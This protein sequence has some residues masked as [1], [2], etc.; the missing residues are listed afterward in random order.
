MKLTFPHMGNTYMVIKVLLDELG[1]DYVIPP[2]NNKKALELGTKH[3][4]EMACLPLKLNLGNY[5]QAIEDGADTILIAGGCGPCRFGYYGEVER[6]ILKDLG[7]GAELI[8]LEVPDSDW[9]EFARRVRKLSGGLK[10]YRIV[11]AV[12]YATLI[13]KEVDELERLTFRLRPREMEKG[14]TDT[15]YKDFK[16]KVIDAKGFKAVK[17]LLE[18]TRSELLNIKVD[19]IGTPLKIG[20]VG[21]IYSAIDPYTNLFLESRLG[22]MGV[23][24]DRKVTLSGWIIEHIL[25]NAFHLPRD[26]GYVEASKP[27]LGAMIGGHAQ[28]TLGNTVIYAKEGYDGVIQVYPLSCMPEIVAES[29]L[30]AVERD[31]GIPVLTLI[32]DEMTGEGGYQTRLEAF[33]DLIK[34]RRERKAFEWNQVLLGN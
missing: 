14:A 20:I 3:A 17:R 26:L 21:E 4:P 12:R 9:R 27:Y 25:K 6:E 29:I 24:V 8:T 22:N 13:S 10:L 11:K 34:M 5:I 32:I 7:Y 1:A 28:E 16:R 19:H 30:P 23:E 2:Y 31:Y 15:I 18:D 33:V